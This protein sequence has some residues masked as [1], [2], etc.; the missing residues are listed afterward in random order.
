MC[1]VATI[2]LYIDVLGFFNVI[3]IIMIIINVVS[4][5]ISSSYIFI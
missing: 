4:S 1:I 5:I 2:M 3:T